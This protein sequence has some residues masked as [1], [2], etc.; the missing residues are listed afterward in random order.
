MKDNKKAAP[1]QENSLKRNNIIG[2]KRFNQLSEEQQTIVLLYHKGELA[3]K[4]IEP[5]IRNNYFPNISKSLRDVFGFD[6]K[7]SRY[8]YTNDLG[9][10]K[11]Y[12]IWYLTPE[13]KE[14]AVEFVGKYL[15]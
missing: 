7:W 3:R 13:D 1:R 5:V 10:P 8:D 2:T 11:W 6:M 4:D 9:K 12:A 14:R 15:L